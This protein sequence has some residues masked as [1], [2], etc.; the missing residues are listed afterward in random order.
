MEKKG[1]LDPEGNNLNP[2]TDKEYTQKY[3]DLA[4]IWSKF[5]AY[6]KANDIIDS[7]T[8]ILSLILVPA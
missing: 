2:L 1:I 5:P 3:L 4:K 8:N 6:N 7:I